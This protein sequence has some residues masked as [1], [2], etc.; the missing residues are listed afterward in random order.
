MSKQV[1]S[2]SFDRVNGGEVAPFTVIILTY[3]E[4]RNIGGCLDSLTKL[5]APV[6]IVDSYSNDGTIEILQ[7]REVRFTQHHFENYARQRNWAQENCPFETEWVLHLDAGERCTPAMV[8][9]LNK[10]FDPNAAIDGYL[11][12]RRTEFLGKW[13]RYGGHY[14]NYHLR[15]FRKM[16]GRC[17]SKAYDQHFVIAEGKVQR[18]SAGIDMID[19]V[20]DTISNF[21][22]SHARWALFEA[23]EIVSQNANSGEVRAR[24]FGNPIERRRWLKSRVFQYSPLFIRAF[25]YFLY[26]YI[27]R[28]GFLDGRMGLIFH[29]LQGFW[30]R[31]LVDSNVTEIQHQLSENGLTLYKHVKETYGEAYLKAINNVG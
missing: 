13:I 31:F 27:I 20:T 30:F 6:F 22:S 12:S 15:L 21:T 11:F 24:L 10:Q 16:K 28:L 5:G 18:L 23:I 19:V 3:N 17:E 1:K 29:V 2:E 26:R 8:S 25:L 14:P 7:E 9:W 4:E